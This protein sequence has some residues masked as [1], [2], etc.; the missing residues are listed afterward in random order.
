MGFFDDEPQHHERR[1]DSPWER[2]VAEF[3]C[4][5][6]TSALVLART[7]AVAVAVIGVWAFRAGFEFWMSA[8]FH[9]GLPP[10]SGA[11]A[12]HQSAHIGLQFADGRKAANFGRGPAL[13]PGTEPGVVLMTAGLGGGLRHR[14]WSY[15]VWPLPPAGPVTFVCEWA[16]AGIAEARADLDAQRILD[17]AARS[18]PLWPGDDR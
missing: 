10:P 5:V 2:P 13:A 16:A 4:A 18:V 3:P 14:S 11:T 6:E 1:R 9:H 7:E 17:A 15:W 8:R 12:P